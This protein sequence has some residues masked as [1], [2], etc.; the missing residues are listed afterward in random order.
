E[1]VSL[2]LALKRGYRHHRIRPIVTVSVEPVEDRRRHRERSR[3]TSQ[4][5]AHPELR[6]PSLRQTTRYRQ[7]VWR[8][9]RRHDSAARERDVV[10]HRARVSYIGN[11]ERHA[12]LRP[13]YRYRCRT[14]LRTHRYG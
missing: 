10:C 6:V 14:T 11:S 9:T 5:G 4:V 1:T 12:S 7:I 8:R 3:S 13:W 2:E